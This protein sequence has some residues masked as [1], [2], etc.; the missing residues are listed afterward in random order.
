MPIQHPPLSRTSSSS[1]VVSD[2]TSTNDE[3]NPPNTPSSGVTDGAPKRTRKRFTSTQLTLLEDLF[4]QTSHPTREQRDALAK[5]AGLCVF[6]NPSHVRF[7][8][9]MNLVSSLGSSLQGNSLRNRLV[10]KQTTDRTKS[11]TLE[12]CRTANTSKAK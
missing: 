7:A 10:P 11:G 9:D 1:S 4:H 3:L 2:G 6:S 12:R 5:E 8:T